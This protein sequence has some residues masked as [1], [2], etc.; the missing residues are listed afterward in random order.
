VDDLAEHLLRL[1]R[2]QGTTVLLVEQNARLAFD[3]CP[4]AYVL[5]AG[6]ITLSGASAELAQSA[7]VQ[8][9]YLGGA[10]DEAVAG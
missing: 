5:E 8:A 2:E 4:R 6:R 7:A 9:A 1:N 3:L 10:T